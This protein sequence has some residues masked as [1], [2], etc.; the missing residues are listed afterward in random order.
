MQQNPEVLLSWGGAESSVVADVSRGKKMLAKADVQCL[1]LTGI[2]EF[3]TVSEI[4]KLAT[5]DVTVDK[6]FL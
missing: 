2:E 1:Q 4:T 5:T 6:P 3:A